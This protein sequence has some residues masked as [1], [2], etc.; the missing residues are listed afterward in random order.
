MK[1]VTCQRN[2]NRIHRNNPFLTGNKRICE[3]NTLKR[4]KLRRFYTTD[5]NHR[6]HTSEIRIQ[7][8][9]LHRRIRN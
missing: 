4:R 7:S 8:I 3:L 5:Q 2:L 6:N 9:Q 1:Q